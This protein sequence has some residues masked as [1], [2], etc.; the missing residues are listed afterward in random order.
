MA[1]QLFLK[2]GDIKGE[3]TDSKHEDEID[4][5]FWAWGMTQQVIV[6]GGGGSSAG[7]VK[8]DALHFTHYVDAASPAIMLACAMGRH[9]NQATLTARK[10]SKKPREFLVIKLKDVIITSVQPTMDLDGPATHEAVSLNFAQVDFQ[11]FPRNGSGGPGGAVKFAWDLVRNR[12][13]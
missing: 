5:L 2:L 8:F 4:V 7:K 10:G 11:Y 3:S 13:L 1:Q 12:P 6:S 9:L